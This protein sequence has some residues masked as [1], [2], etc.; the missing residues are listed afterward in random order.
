MVNWLC[1]GIIILNLW[2]W[3][4]FKKIK[5]LNK[6]LLKM[7]SKYFENLMETRKLWLLILYEILCYYIIAWE[8]N[9]IWTSG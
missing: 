1:I 8:W 6:T 3:I 9:W 4:K 5:V 7:F 2:Y